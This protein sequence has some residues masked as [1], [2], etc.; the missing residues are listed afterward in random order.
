M[1]ADD[2]LTTL[3]TTNV[4]SVKRLYALNVYSSYRSSECTQPTGKMSKETC[5]FRNELESTVIYAIKSSKSSE[6]AGKYAG[7]AAS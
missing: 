6:I 2:R 7:K 4:I 5:V 3:I 1:S